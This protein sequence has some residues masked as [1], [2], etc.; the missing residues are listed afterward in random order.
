MDPPSS[1]DIVRL[2]FLLNN[3]PETLPYHSEGQTFHPQLCS[4]CISD[5]WAK[6]VGKDGAMN[7]QLE[8]ALGPRKDGGIFP[9]LERGPA[10]TNLGTILESYSI[11]FPDSFFVNNWIKDAVASVEFSFKENKTKLPDLTKSS[12]LPLQQKNQRNPLPNQV[13]VLEGS[14]GDGSKKTAAVEKAQKKGAGRPKKRDTKAMTEEEIEDARF[15]DQL[16][17]EDTRKGGRQPMALLAKITRIAVGLSGNDEGKTVVRCICSRYCD[18]REVSAKGIRNRQRI[19]KHA[20]DCGWLGNINGGVWKTE[21]IQALAKNAHNSGDE[22]DENELEGSDSGGTLKR[23]HDSNIDAGTDS[24]ETYAEPP[25]RK[26][27]FQLGTSDHPIHLDE[28]LNP[29]D[30]NGKGA[31]STAGN[32]FGAFKTKGRKDLEASANHNL[33]KLVA[34]N[35][36]PVRLVGSSELKDFCYGLNGLY[37]LPSPTTFSDTLLPNVAAKVLLDMLKYLEGFYH[38]QISFD[39]G[40]LRRKGFYTVTVT[41]PHRQS[42]T[43]ELDDGTRLSHTANYVVEILEK[44]TTK[45]G[46]YRFSGTSSDSTAVTLKARKDFCE[47]FPHILNMND[48]CHNLQNT[49]K[50]LC[51]LPCFAQVISQ[52]RD[53]LTYMSQSTYARDHFDFERGQLKIAR[54]LEAVTDHRF[55]TIY[56]SAESVMRGI[57]A[58][59]NIA[60]DAGI[61]LTNKALHFFKDDEDIWP[62][63]R[64]LKRLIT[65]LK[66]F[67]RS[68]QCLEAHDTTPD[69]VYR[70]WLAILAQLHDLFQHGQNCRLEIQV[71]EQIRR[72]VNRRYSEL[73]ENPRAQNV[74]LVAFFLVPENRSAEILKRPNPLAVPR[75]TLSLQRSAN[76]SR[77]P[78][79]LKESPDTVKK[80]GI[81][82]LG[83]LRNE[84]GDIY[85]PDVS[86]ED[87]RKEMAKRNPFLAKYTP[88]EALTRLKSQFTAYTNGESPF[89]FKKSFTKPIREWWVQLAKHDDADVL[90]A[91]AIKI[92]SALPTSMTEERAVSIV[93][94]INSA[95]RNKQSVA[96]VSQ[97][98][99]VRQWYR[100]DEASKTK[101]RL[102]VKWRDL[103]ATVHRPLRSRPAQK[104]STAT[105]SF[106]D[107]TPTAASTAAASTNQASLEE[108]EDDDEDEDVEDALRWLDEPQEEDIWAW[109]YADDSFTAGEMVDI[110]HPDLLDILSDAPVKRGFTD[111]G[112]GEAVN[113]GGSRKTGTRRVT[114]EDAIPGENDWNSF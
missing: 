42:F 108:G 97:Q 71:I 69:D 88:A 7:Q 54:G 23:K 21:A 5:E 8:A 93:T 86:L 36:L 46:P 48:A 39:G 24:C 107:T 64:D 57:P 74:Y 104:P 95:R 94:W 49:M 100:M 101:D 26:R 37:H 60:R 4:W 44:W 96:T 47:K 59:T 15:R 106:E 17:K 50:D 85:R 90:A 22:V 98:L 66:P 72:I 92:F 53:I 91:I 3:L 82:V 19:L 113:V 114:M 105:G 34:C 58:F 20:A 27:K 109:P 68:L 77:A 61:G 41:T 78:I 84:Y 10:M 9:I 32:P 89:V 80:I 79:T 45:I 11:E 35:G 31:K 76:N 18:Q 83:I 13:E 70:Y 52:L 14:G 62:F 40:K 28:P 81:S 12:S 103:P 30:A 99:R 112:S 110:T 38:L 87:A 67:A 75:V 29:K 55:G 63:Q 51:K 73:I 2:N 111:T 56:W 6:D 16:E 65:L 1:N 102:S 33:V 43:L 25:P